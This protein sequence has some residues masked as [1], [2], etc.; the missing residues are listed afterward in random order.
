MQKH[1]NNGKNPSRAKF[2]R[3]QFQDPSLQEIISQ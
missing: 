2:G 3:A 1:E